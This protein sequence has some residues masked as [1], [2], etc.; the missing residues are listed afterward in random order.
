MKDYNM[1]TPADRDPVLWEIARMRASF[2]SHLFS[3]VVVNAAL[4]A[5]WFTTKGYRWDNVDQFHTPW[6]V[7]P[8]IGWGIGLAFHFLR[9]Y[10]YPYTNSVEHEYQKLQKENKTSNK[11]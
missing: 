6:P 2:K 9:A 1:P 7:W 10:V 11:I 8:M 4:W 3:Y 5:I